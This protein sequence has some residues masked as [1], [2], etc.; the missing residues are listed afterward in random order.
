MQRNYWENFYHTGKVTDY[1]RYRDSAGDTADG[2]GEYPD[3]DKVSN[4]ME[5]MQYGG[6]S[7]GNGAVGHPG[8]RL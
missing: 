4:R 3:K 8:W 2:S 7:D 1:L 5:S 6:K